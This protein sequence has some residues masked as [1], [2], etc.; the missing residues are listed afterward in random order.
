MLLPLLDFIFVR[1]DASCDVIGVQPIFWPEAVLE[2]CGH[3]IKH[4][5]PHRF[6]ARYAALREPAGYLCFNGAAEGDE[7][8]IWSASKPAA[9]LLAY[10][11]DPLIRQHRSART[12]LASGAARGR[13]YVRLLS[14]FWLS[15]NAGDGL[16]FAVSCG[17]V[18]AS[19]FNDALNMAG[20]KLDRIA[21]QKSPHTSARKRRFEDF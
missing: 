20:V 5:R 6:V 17:E 12:V 4:C 3:F 2:R 15:G 21:V 9:G 16:G 1:Q 13:Q 19:A 11:D 18:G 14:L 7:F 10:L 8:G